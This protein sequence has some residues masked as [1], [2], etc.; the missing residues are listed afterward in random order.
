MTQQETAAVY[1]QLTRS[2]QILFLVN[3]IHELTVYTRGFYSEVPL[4]VNSQAGSGVGNL[5]E[6]Q[7][8]VSGQLHDVLIE[9]EDRADGQSFIDWIMVWAENGRITQLL[10][11]AIET[12]ISSCMHA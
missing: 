6:I 9:K 5:N 12:A 3:L 1:D 8:R 10:H 11:Q 2:D 4:I 7:H